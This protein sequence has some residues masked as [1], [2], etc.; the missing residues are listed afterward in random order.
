MGAN[1]SGLPGQDGNGKKDQ[2]EKKTK[3]CTH[4]LIV[5]IEMGATSTN[6][7]WKE[8]KKGRSGIKQA[9]ICLSYAFL[10]ANY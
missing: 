5:I 8:E 3:V 10:F 9:A 7:N 1:Q 4:F 2:G 6:K